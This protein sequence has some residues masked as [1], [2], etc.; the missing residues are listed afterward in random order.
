MKHCARRWRSS[1]DDVPVI[2]RRQAWRRLGTA[3]AYAMARFDDLKEV[4]AVTLVHTWAMA[5]TR[6]HATWQGTLR[7][8]PHLQPQCRRVSG[9]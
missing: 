6:S 4:D 1:P 2:S 8:L 5:S 3:A 9:T 7:A